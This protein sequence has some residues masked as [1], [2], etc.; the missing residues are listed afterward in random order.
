MR[1]F[2]TTLLLAAVLA[3]SGCRL[4]TECVFNALVNATGP[5][6]SSQNRNAAEPEYRPSP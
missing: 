5:S 3:T 2:S 4:A 6:H 1:C